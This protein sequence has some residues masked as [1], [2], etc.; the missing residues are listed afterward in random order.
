MD[1]C[2]N[3]NVYMC[4]RVQVAQCACVHVCK[5]HMIPSAE[6]LPN[7]LL[8]LIWRS[9]STF[10]PFKNVR[11]VVDFGSE[12][13]HLSST[14]ERLLKNTMFWERVFPEN[15]S[16]TL[17][18]WSIFDSETIT[19]QVTFRHLQFSCG[20]THVPAVGNCHFQKS[21]ISMVSVS[22]VH[23][24][25]TSGAQSYYIALRTL[26][27][28]IHLTWEIIMFSKKCLALQVSCLF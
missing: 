14:F 22:E 10:D 16:K 4:T 20:Y 12:I 23:R 11:Q 6:Y 19:K 25:I 28:T 26:R 21:D 15:H 2:T 24:V 8:L 1:M 27:E 3:S 13:D 9:N 17:D 18:R 7:S 5:L